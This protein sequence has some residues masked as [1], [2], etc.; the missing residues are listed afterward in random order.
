MTIEL[1]IKEDKYKLLYTYY[2]VDE[3]RI[4][5]N[6][7]TFGRKGELEFGGTIPS[8]GVIRVIKDKKEGD[9]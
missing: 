4:K 3:L 5:D 6:S 7:L 1:E 2:D 8:N 9:K